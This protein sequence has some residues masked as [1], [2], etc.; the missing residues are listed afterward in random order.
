MTSSRS[1]WQKML[2]GEP[3][4][5]SDAALV[6]AR[7]RARQLCRQLNQGEGDT[8]AVLHQLLG[9][10]GQH[11]HIN[12]PFFCDYGQHIRVG[13]NFYAN[14]NCTMLDVCEVVIGDDVL[15]GPNV[16]IYTAAH[17]IA[18]APRMA[19][20]EFGAPITIGHRVWIGGGS[21]LC[22][23]ITIGD[24]SVIGAGSV[25]TRDIPAGVIAVGHPCRV[26]RAMTTEELAGVAMTAT[27]DPLDNA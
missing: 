21:I 12:P 14:V 26:L 13:E 20:V 1:E 10:R 6:A 23:G 19:G 9:Q 25:V 8:D 18:V 2:A 24:N 5:A 4:D 11:C 15:L 7:Q 3:Y 17:P 27:T 22:P 16:Q